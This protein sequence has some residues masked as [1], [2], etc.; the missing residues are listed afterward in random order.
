VRFLVNLHRK[1]FEFELID[2]WILDRNV[3]DVQEQRAA[4]EQCFSNAV[5]TDVVSRVVY[6]ILWPQ[7]D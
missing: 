6:G 5:Y 7:P 1:V 3:H 2:G 4:G